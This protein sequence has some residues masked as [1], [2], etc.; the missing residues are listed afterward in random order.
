MSDGSKG[1]T[2]GSGST[3]SDK[4]AV[5]AT[6]AGSQTT[7]SLR[8]GWLEKKGAVNKNWKQRWFHLANGQLD[9]Y[10]DK[11]VRNKEGR[12]G[13]FSLLPLNTYTDTRERPVAAFE[14]VENQEE[15]LHSIERRH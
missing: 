1:S 14:Y 5:E 13:P 10:V 11:D 15:G 9:Y 7:S 3:D 8:E 6:Q 4:V 12:F 2:S